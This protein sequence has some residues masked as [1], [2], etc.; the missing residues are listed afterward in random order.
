MHTEGNEVHVDAEEASGGEKTGVMRWVLG[1]GT[2]LA[3]LGL[4]AI[5]IFGAATSDTIGG[6]ADM[7]GKIDAVEEMETGSSNTDGII[8]EDE[9]SDDDTVMDDGVEVIEN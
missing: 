3:I 1:I 8:M 2:L 5:W 7:T 9:M 4:S 6:Q